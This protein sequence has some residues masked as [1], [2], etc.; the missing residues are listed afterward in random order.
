[1][2]QFKILILFFFMFFCVAYSQAQSHY[3]GMWQLKE[4]KH[5]GKPVDLTDCENYTFFKFGV[6]DNGYYRVLYSNDSNK[7]QKSKYLLL[8]YEIVE[9]NTKIRFL[10]KNNN[11]NYDIFDTFEI[12]QMN[13]YQLFLSNKIDSMIIEKVN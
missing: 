2:K 3:E 10:K 4:L 9:N 5:N 7:C 6:A 13:D 12:F 8:F 1:M 11:G